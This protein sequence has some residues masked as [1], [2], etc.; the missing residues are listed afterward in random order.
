MSIFT[1]IGA[2][3]KKE[4]SDILQDADKVAITLTEGIKTALVGGVLG[5]M[6]EGLDFLTKSNVPTEIVTLISNN[7]DKVLA[8][9]LAIQGLPA[10]PTAADI[11]AFEQRV[12]T[13]FG[14]T[15][16][17]SKL[18]TTLAAQIYGIIQTQNQAGT[19]FT[20]AVLVDDVEQAYQDYLTDQTANATT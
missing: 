2:W 17:T 8:V 16:D 1:K 14:V 11:L 7:I 20:F 5:F 6:A 10:T 9:E 13:A 19:K 15:S 4:F 12:L 18:Y 3:F